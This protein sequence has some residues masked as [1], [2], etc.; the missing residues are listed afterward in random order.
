[1][2]KVKMTHDTIAISGLVMAE[3]SFEETFSTEAEPP[4][5]QAPVIAVQ[6]TKPAQE[7]ADIAAQEKTPEVA[8]T[9]AANA[10]PAKDT[11]SVLIDDKKASGN[12]GDSENKMP[13]IVGATAALTGL[14]A[15][16]SKK[17]KFATNSSASVLATAWS[18]RHSL[19]RQL[20]ERKYSIIV[21]GLAGAGTRI[22][23]KFIL[24]K[25]ITVP[26]VAAG[27][28][29]LPTVLAGIGI[30]ASTAI[31]AGAVSGAA[32]ELAREAFNKKSAK[33]KGW[34]LKALRKGANTGALSGLIMG[35]VADLFMSNGFLNEYVGKPVSEFASAHMPDMSGVKSFFNKVL[36]LGSLKQIFAGA[37]PLQQAQEAT[38]MDV[39]SLQAVAAEP[40]VQAPLPSVEVAQAAAPTPQNTP[41]Q[42]VFEAP[43]SEAPAAPEVQPAAPAQT[44]AAD[45]AA[46][47]I[48]KVPAGFE[49]MISSETYDLLGKDAAGRAVQ[50]KMLA[51]ALHPNDNRDMLGAIKEASKYLLNHTNGDLAARQ[52]GINM[53][54]KGHA[55]IAE[56]ARLGGSSVSKMIE[57]DYGYVRKV[58][59]GMVAKS[60]PAL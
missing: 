23:A 20:N 10:T 16:M 13:L 33:E 9:V 51:A 55:L 2:R 46:P 15:L 36:D 60:A 22:G 29:S 1:M 41:V 12:D 3:K 58:F 40:A 14:A 35:G 39:S 25:L 17:N 7:A 53:L 44:V 52:A 48:S 19:I 28:M 24:A 30:A 21:G 49:K 57:R 31:L 47:T 54:E 32:A 26:V 56:N 8:P 5:E 50:K 42:M 34:Q 43:A 27:A 37:N 38:S 6:E 18:H 45:A 59:A 11:L 4:A